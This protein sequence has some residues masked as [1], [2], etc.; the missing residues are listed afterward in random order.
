MLQCQLH[1]IFTSC[2][3]VLLCVV[4]DVTF[5]PRSG[6]ISMVVAVNFLYLYTMGY[7]LAPDKTFLRQSIAEEL[8]CAVEPVQGACWVRGSGVG[9]DQ[10][11]EMLQ[12]SPSGVMTPWVPLP[13]S[14]I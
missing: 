14:I 6:R 7:N 8:L 12:Q 5:H 4:K 11:T 13:G 3:G 1:E 2:I 10:S 9:I